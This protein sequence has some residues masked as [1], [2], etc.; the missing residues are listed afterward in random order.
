MSAQNKKILKNISPTAWEHPADRAALSALRGNA[1]LNEIVK[2]VLGSLN[3]T[4]LRLLALSSHVRVGPTQFPE[5]YRLHKE[6]CMI[7]DAPF[8][9]EL[10]ISNSPL[11]NART[12]GINTPIIV[13]N[14]S[15]LDS[16]SPEEIQYVIAHELGHGLSGHMLYN[17]LIWILDLMRMFLM[18]PPVLYFHLIASFI[19]FSHIAHISP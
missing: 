18:S 10:Y 12:T 7:L 1:S 5:I 8:V 9:P 13:L 4:A 6:A 11:F 16:L 15:L 19:I 2:K 3:D 17:T 14:S